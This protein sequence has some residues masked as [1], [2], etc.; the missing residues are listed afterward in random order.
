M[1]SQIKEPGLQRSISFFGLIALG[2]GGIWGTS[3]LL[4]SS[5]WMSVGGG[6][7][8]ALLAWVLV[9]FLELPLVLAYRQAVPMFPQAEGEMSYSAAAF[10]QLA[11]FIAGWFGILVNMIVCAY[12]VVSIVRMVE[13]LQPS[14]TKWYWYK[15]MGSPVGIITI[16]IGLALV[17]GITVLHYRGVR[18]S[19]TFQN[20]T[21]TTL[22]ILVGV[23]V[24]LAFSMGTFKNFQPLF[25][26]PAWVGI[27]AVATMLPFSLAGWET[28]AKGA[29]EA[30][31]KG[32]SAGRTVPIAWSVGWIA[33]TL[34][35]IATGLVMSW[36]AG[37]EADIPFATGLN[38]LTGTNLPGILLIVTA[39]I[40][41]V[42][43]YNALFYGVTRQMFGMA[44]RGLLPAGL[45]KV[46]PKYGTP[47]NAIL[48]TTAVMVIS[49]FIGRKF[50][51][52][53]VDAASFAYIILWG[54]TFLSIEVL[55]RKLAAKG[56]LVPASG[57]IVVRL[58]GYISIVFF[59]V[60]MLYPKSPGAL[61]WPLEHI[62]LAGLVVLG[63]VLYSL[64]SNKTLDIAGA[65]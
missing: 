29:E 25:G 54:G 55:R 51:I 56:Q 3:W 44:R 16:A 10:G 40:G 53:L 52:P 63:L 35:L 21:S 32:S 8:N 18:L 7:V 30:K 34:S 50:L 41:V 2:L 38:T 39:I 23:G 5:T 61:I 22:M 60:A 45:A 31:E 33:Y 1:S 37:A 46:H 26:K 14:V 15:I 20:I 27:I 57:G 17:I 65:D 42:G 12:E 6:V 36:Q 24:I 11:G 43:V 49:P 48:L 9:L 47:V 58:L 28:I 64:R 13:F 19:S 4:V 62:I 59:M